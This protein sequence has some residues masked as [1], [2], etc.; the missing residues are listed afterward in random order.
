[1]PASRQRKGP[2]RRSTKSGLNSKQIKQVKKIALS[3]GELNHLDTAISSASLT[4]SS[5]FTLNSFFDIGQGDAENQRV[6]DQLQIK[7]LKINVRIS[8]GSANGIVR[9]VMWQQL[10]D[11]QPTGMGGYSNLPPGDFLPTIQVSITKYKVLKD[12]YFD[13][14]SAGKNN[15][16]LKIRIPAKMLAHKKINFDSGASTITGPGKIHFKLTTNNTTASQM[17]VDGNARASYYD[18]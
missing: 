16:F 15:K 4:A 3:Q 1:M 11:A 2:R 10:D 8:A 6:G 14:N 17:V 7:D 9:C 18:Q 12:F 13:L 5:A